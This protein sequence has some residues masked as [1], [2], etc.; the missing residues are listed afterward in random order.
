M[1]NC[2]TFTLYVLSRVRGIMEKYLTSNLVMESSL[3]KKSDFL[4]DNGEFYS[5]EVR[6]GVEICRLKI[7]DDC[8]KERSGIDVGSY[9]T[10]Y[11]KAL[12]SYSE[13]ELDGLSTIVADELLRLINA[14]IERKNG[15]IDV[16]VV[17]LGNRDITSDSLGVG[18]TDI[19]S[20][21]R[22]VA[23]LDKKMFESGY[24][25]SVSAISCGVFGKTGIET[26]EILRGIVS[27]ISPDVIIAVDALAAREYDRLASVIQLSDA[28]IVPG[29]GIGNRRDELSQQTLSVP[30]ISVGIPTVVSAATFVCDNLQKCGYTK[31]DTDMERR[32]DKLKTLYVTP[33]DC[34]AL[35][36][37]STHL[38]SRSIEAALL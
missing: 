20:V 25:S 3:I 10:I 24:S 27:Q 31:L 33:K 21:T 4:K 16:L 32:L 22:H 34:D 23:I 28:G 35:L 26:L 5:S 14:R 1:H 17:G 9:T 36:R 37:V 2:K 7:R 13:S 15:K 12:T 8:E 11:T 38:I 30:V 29:A 18:V 19:L 6:D